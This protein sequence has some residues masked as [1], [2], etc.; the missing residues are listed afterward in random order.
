MEEIGKLIQ[1]G[2]DINA[3]DEKGLTPLLGLAQSE[4]ISE[5]LVEIFSLLIQTRSHRQFDSKMLS[6]YCANFIKN[7]NVIDVITLFIKSGFKVTDETRDF[8]QKNY[9]KTNRTQV[10][11]SCN[12]FMYKQHPDELA[13]YNE[14]P[15]VD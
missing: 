3:K 14:W 8:L 13:N 9:R 12:Y 6:P 4:K 15:P 1:E 11:Q 10:L 2:A 5:N 7:E